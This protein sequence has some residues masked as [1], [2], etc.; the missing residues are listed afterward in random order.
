MDGFA[1]RVTYEELE[2]KRQALG[3]WGTQWEFRGDHIQPSIRR[4]MS[5]F[6]FRSLISNFEAALQVPLQEIVSQI[7]C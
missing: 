4:N 7:K 1:T 5:S 2:A 3:Q 6:F